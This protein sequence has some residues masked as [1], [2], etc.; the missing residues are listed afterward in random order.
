MGDLIGPKSTEKIK[1]FKSWK[2]CFILDF[3]IIWII[4]LLN[5]KLIPS[6]YI[7]IYYIQSKYKTQSEK[8]LK[9]LLR[10]LF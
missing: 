4:S 1:K 6:K 7:G 10:Q 8:I 9:F 2:C 5:S 3:S